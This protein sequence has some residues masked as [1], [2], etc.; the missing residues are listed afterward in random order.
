MT[1]T[2]DRAGDIADQPLRVAIVGTGA[3]ARL[4]AQTLQEMPRVT[5]VAAA[6]TLP[7]RA[8]EFASAHGI[9]NAYSSFDD[10]LAA[11][12]IDVVHLCTPP[13]GHAGQA[14]IAFAHGAHVV[15][16]K[17]PALSLAD[18]DTMTDAATKAGRRLAV[19]F[20][21]RTGSAVRHIRKLL[22]SGAFGRPLVAL[23]Q[24]LWY[25]DDDYFEVPWR[26]R[27]ETEGGGTTL[28]HGIHQIDLLAHLLGDWRLVQGQLWRLER[29]IDTEDVSTGT[30]VFTS[31][32]VA[33]VV[34]SVLSPRETS[35]IRIDTDKATIEVDHLYGH[36]HTNWRITPALGVSE[37]EAAGWA[38]PADEVQSGHEA[39]LDEVYAALETGGELPAVADH[40]ARALE[41]VSA[42]YASGRENAVIERT[43]IVSEPELRGGMRAP[44]TPLQQG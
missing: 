8:A 12:K 25:R 44:V 37:S 42:L 40:P 16:E 36:D 19:V 31:G 15:V 4:H 9:P 2:N 20:Q 3:V 14:V 32:A 41:I 21:Q 13:G 6:D 27:W 5:I 24:T 23:C 30:I 26:G 43:R 17:P 11:H 39:L 38:L 34:N 22:E 33:S 7:G 35:N 29:D 1:I 28:S 10:L 18:L